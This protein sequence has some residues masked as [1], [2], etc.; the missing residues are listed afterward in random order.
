MT[1][2]EI[3]NTKQSVNGLCNLARKLGYKDPLYQLQNS[4]GSNVGD[5][6]Y[7]FEDNPGAIEAVIGWAA[8]NHG[9]EDSSDE[10]SDE[11]ECDE[12]EDS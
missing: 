12:D 7:F 1:R 8:E 10:D 3:E 4:D 11:E 9:N 5:L 6:L 2:D